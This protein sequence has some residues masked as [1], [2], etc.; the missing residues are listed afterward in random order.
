MLHLHTWKEQRCKRW[1]PGPKTAGTSWT[2]FSR[3][4]LYK[5]EVPT[6]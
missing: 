5:P 6:K 4:L 1:T 2:I 3:V